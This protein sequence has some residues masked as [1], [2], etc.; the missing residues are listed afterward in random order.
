M[1]KN[2]SERILIFNA[3]HEIANRYSSVGVA[4]K[5]HTYGYISCAQIYGL[6]G[7]SC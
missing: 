4:I 1:Y 6:Q 5:E 2:Q 3:C 7:R